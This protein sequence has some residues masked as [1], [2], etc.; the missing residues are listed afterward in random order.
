[1]SI[2]GSKLFLFSDCLVFYKMSG[3]KC[4]N[5]C[6]AGHFSLCF[7]CINNNVMK[8]CEAIT[9]LFG[10]FRLNV[11]LCCKKRLFEVFGSHQWN[12]KLFSRNK[13]TRPWDTKM[14]NFSVYIWIAGLR[15]AQP[16]ALKDL[17][18]CGSDSARATAGRSSSAMHICSWLIFKLIILY[19]LLWISKWPQE[20]KW[21]PTSEVKKK[22]KIHLLIF[23]LRLDH[24]ESYI[25]FLL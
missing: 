9:L 7:I 6:D 3:P 15:N 12:A 18:N 1:M 23:N 2:Y 17:W 16:C 20:K 21:L 8:F 25:K 24:K 5:S 19:G 13:E 14:Y 4:S 22:K 11:I 10:Y